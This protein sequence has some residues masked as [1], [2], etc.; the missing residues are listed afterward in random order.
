MA[1]RTEPVLLEEHGRDE[2]DISDRLDVFRG[3]DAE[4]RADLLIVFS[5]RDLIVQILFAGRKK[6]IGFGAVVRILGCKQLPSKLHV[7]LSALAMFR[8]LRIE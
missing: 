1:S 6:Q 2:G 4:S 7:T 3:L 8:P 5:V